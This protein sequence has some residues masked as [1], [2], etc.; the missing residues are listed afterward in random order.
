MMQHYVLIGT[1]LSAFGCSAMLPG[2]P[3]CVVSCRVAVLQTHLCYVGVFRN[4]FCAMI[5]AQ[6]QCSTALFQIFGGD[7]S[8]DGTDG[9]MNMCDVFHA[10]AVLM[11]LVV[12]RLITWR[13]VWS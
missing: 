3:H 5:S 7:V 2:L 6:G 1:L 11:R 8:N 10:L 9:L 4:V 12:S 13:R